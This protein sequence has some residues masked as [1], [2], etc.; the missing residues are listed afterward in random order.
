MLDHPAFKRAFIGPRKKPG[1]EVTQTTSCGFRNA[2]TRHR[3]PGFERIIQVFS[4]V[5]NAGFALNAQ[6]VLPQ[7]LPPKFIDLLIFCEEAMP[8]D[9][10]EVPLIFQRAAEPADP[11]IFFDH[12][13]GHLIAR[14][15]VGARK[16]RGARSQH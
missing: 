15:L 5:K 16:P 6:E 8:S 3:I 12:R 13:D 10:E 9:V 14:K 11:G 4:F 7:D 1:R 2:E